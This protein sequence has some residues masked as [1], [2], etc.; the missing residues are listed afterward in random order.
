[1]I[2]ART[3][4]ARVLFRFLAVVAPGCRAPDTPFLRFDIETERV[5][6]APPAQENGSV[7]RVAGERRFLFG[8]RESLWVASAAMRAQTALIEPPAQGERRG[9][10]RR[11][12]ST[13]IYDF[14]RREIWLSTDGAA[15]TRQT[16]DEYEYEI[17]NTRRLELVEYVDAFVRDA[18][19]RGAEHAELYRGDGRV[20][21]E[22]PGSDRLARARAAVI[23]GHLW[24]L[25]VEAPQGDSAPASWTVARWLFRALGLTAA[26]GQAL[27]EKVGGLPVLLRGRGAPSG[28]SRYETVH[29]VL[30]VDPVALPDGFFEPPADDASRERSLAAAVRTWD[31]FFAL[32][33]DPA[34]LPREGRWLGV[35]LDLERARSGELP[36]RIEE[37]WIEREGALRV[38]L[39]RLAIRQQP[40]WARPRLEALISGSSAVLA[41]D[42][43]EALV[44]EDDPEEPRAIAAVFGL[45]SRRRQYTD[46]VD[47]AAI[48]GWALPRLRVLSGKTYEELA[49]EVAPLWSGGEAPGPPGPS[50]PFESAARELDFWLRWWEGRRESSG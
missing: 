44:F 21:V 2:L 4:T 13:W 8:A 49:A 38:E 47:P 27:A 15:W 5:E 29:R 9:A 12:S 43:C 42:A 50:D 1:V 23:P 6:L 31:D 41:L 19:V 3:T 26:E 37:E 33:D 24:E 17:E 25:V 10:A 30:D 45:L 46:G 32:L 36:E 48:V 18:A 35:L 16:L 40:Q 39:M 7:A 20:D 34:K 11:R 28:A 22:A 14:D